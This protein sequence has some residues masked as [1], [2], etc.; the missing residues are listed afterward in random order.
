MY[1][2]YVF[3]LKKK[4]YKYI[5]SSRGR[6]GYASK[7]KLYKCARNARDKFPNKRKEKLGSRIERRENK[8][9]EK[10]MFEVCK[11]MK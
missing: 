10:M 9:E 2:L 11:N 1:L 8:K 7:N 3:G 5:Q 4:K 6:Y